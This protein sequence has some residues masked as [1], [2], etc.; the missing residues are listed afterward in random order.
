MSFTLTIADSLNN[1]IVGGSTVTITPGDGLTLRGI[2]ASFTIPDAQSF[3]QTLG[4][5]NA[6]S[7]SVVD[8]VSK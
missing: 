1:P 4:G 8:A 5:I 7:F 2:P 6:F 3:G